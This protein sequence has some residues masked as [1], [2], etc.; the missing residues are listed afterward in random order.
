MFVFSA[1]PKVS[2]L[3]PD[4]GAPQDVMGVR[5]VAL[6][7]DCE[8]SLVLECN[9]SFPFL[10]DYQKKQFKNYLFHSK[11]KYVIY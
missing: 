6:S 3:I 8:L 10:V 2:K 4:V 9:S 5:E 7:P 11:N 1:M